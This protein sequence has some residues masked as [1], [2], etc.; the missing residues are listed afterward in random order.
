MAKI[1]NLC[2]TVMKKIPRTHLQLIATLILFP[3]HNSNILFGFLDF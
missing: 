2:N 1:Q 3:Y